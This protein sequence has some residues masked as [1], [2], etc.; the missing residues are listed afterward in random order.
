MTDLVGREFSVGPTTY[1]IEEKIDGGGFGIVYRADPKDGATISPAPLP[2]VVKMPVGDLLGD[3]EWMRR[4]EREARI[5]GNISHPNVVRTLGLL[6][7]D[8]GVPVIVQEYVR[9]AVTFGQWTASSKGELLSVLLQIL[10]A[11]RATHGTS[12]DSRAIHRD[13]SPSNILIT[14]AATAKVIDFGLAK[15]RARTTT[16]LTRS[17]RIFGTP[18]CMAPEQVDST[19]DVDHRADFFALGR[20]ITSC[21]QRRPPQFG[22]AARLEPPLRAIVE[23]LTAF[24]VDDRFA[25]AEA[26]IC[27]TLHDYHNIGVPPEHPELHFQEFASWTAIPNEWATV[28]CSYF[29]GSAS[30]LTYSALRLATL[31]HAPL[32]SNAHFQVDAVFQRLNSEAIEGRF[33]SGAASFDD[34]DPIGSLIVSWYLHLHPSVRIDAFRR[35]CSMSLAYHRYHTMGCV[36]AAYAKEPDPVIRAQ[37]LYHL[38]AIDSE[39]V[40]HGHSTI[41]GR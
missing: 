25:D 33:G 40:I 18:G 13:L 14:P 22:E 28:A 17:G 16:I 27:R 11:L 30:P 38:D 39:K 20:T 6:T 21:L 7:Y 37:L 24:D 34:C 15:E 35:L 1:R 5:L 10:Y 19:R 23:Q 31:V 4:F 29:L 32:L 26:V 36:R 8:D 9:D 2:L 12:A 41:P 3:I